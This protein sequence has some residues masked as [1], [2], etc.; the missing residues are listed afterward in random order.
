MVVGWRAPK[1]SNGQ[2]LS[3]VVHL[4][5]TSDKEGLIMT[6]DSDQTYLSVSE[7]SLNRRFDAHVRVRRLTWI[8]T[9][10]V[11]KLSSHAQY[12]VFMTL[13]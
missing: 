4:Y 7:E 13:K 6:V 10:V 3:Y 9:S 5:T 8:I 12:N 2:L 1:Q 11:N